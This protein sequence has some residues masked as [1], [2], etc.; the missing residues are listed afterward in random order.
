MGGETRTENKLLSISTLAFNWKLDLQVQMPYCHAIKKFGNAKGKKALGQE[1]RWE[2]QCNTRIGSKRSNKSLCT[3]M[4]PPRPRTSSPFFS[5]FTSCL[6][7]SFRDRKISPL[8]MRF[9]LTLTEVNL[10][11]KN[12]HSPSLEQIRKRYT[13]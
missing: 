4:P 5:Y 11:W 2:S 7:I 12:L 3:F 13:G 1:C 8:G 6:K 9:Q 10:V